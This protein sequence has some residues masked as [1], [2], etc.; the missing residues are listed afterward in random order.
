MELIHRCL[1]DDGLA[2]VHT[3]GR[4][5]SA[6]TTDPWISTYIFPHGHLPSIKQIGQSMEGLFVMEDWHN[7][8]ANYDKTLMAWFNNFNSNWENL[9]S[10]YPDPFYKMWKY[11]LLSCAAAFRAREIQLWQVVLSKRGVPGGYESIR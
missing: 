6:V 3:I 2:L 8:S 11:Y 10:A 1:K 7:F 5:A 4:N 9:R